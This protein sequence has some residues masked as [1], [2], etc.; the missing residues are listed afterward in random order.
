[1]TNEDYKRLIVE[2]LEEIDSQEALISVYAVVK[3]LAKQ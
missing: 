2:S 1:M 3:E